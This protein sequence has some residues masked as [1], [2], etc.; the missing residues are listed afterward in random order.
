VTVGVTVLAACCAAQH[1][2]R[3]APGIARVPT[4]SVHFA[5]AIS[6]SCASTSMSSVATFSADDR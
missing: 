3:R 4:N 5:S 6:H 2:F 1:W